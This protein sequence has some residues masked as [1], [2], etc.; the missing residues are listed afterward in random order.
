ME[1]PIAFLM[2]Y[3]IEIIVTLHTRDNKTVQGSMIL[4][5][6]VQPIVVTML[7]IVATVSK[8]IQSSLAVFLFSLSC[9][10]SYSILLLVAT[11]KR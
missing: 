10:A 8:D 7:M 3:I 11:I 4:V 1:I 6:I 2:I 5:A 9:F